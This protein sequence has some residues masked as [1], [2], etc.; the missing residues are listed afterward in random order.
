MRA[1]GAPTGP[2]PI[3]A[4]HEQFTP[5]P[6]HLASVL[7]APIV[8]VFRK[9]DVILPTSWPRCVSDAVKKVSEARVSAMHERARAARCIAGAASVD[10]VRASAAA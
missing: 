3:S 8:A 6:P 4:G 7:I 9:R 1:R 10:I 2:P 5:T